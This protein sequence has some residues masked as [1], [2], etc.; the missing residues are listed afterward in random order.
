MQNKTRIIFRA[1]GNS[2]IG[3]GHVVRSLALA[4]MLCHDFECIFAIQ[5]PSP[6]LQEQI[7]QTCDGVIIL[8]VCHYEE[9]RFIYELQA[10]IA[11]D[12][13]VVLDGYHF[14]TA[15]QQNIKRRGCQL[16]CIDDIHTYPFVADYILNQAGGVDAAKYKTASYTKL[17]LGPAF[18]L[19]RPPFLAAAKAE[20]TL[21]AGDVRVFLNLGGADP[22]NHTLQIAKELARIPGIK[23]VEVTVG[24]AY[25]HLPDLQEWVK[26][27]KAYSLHQNLNAEELCQ[28]MQKC[29]V[30]VTS[31]SGVAYEYASVGGRLFI[32]QTAD[33]QA[34]LYTFLTQNNIAQKYEQLEQALQAHLPDSFQQAVKIQRQYLDGRSDERLKQVFQRMALAASITIRCVSENDLMLLF[35]W[36]NDPEVRRYSFNTNPILLE[37]HT[38]WLKTKLE[39]K[40]AKLYVAEA[41]G[42]PLA[43][44]RFEV[45]DSRATISYLL[46]SDFR[47]KGMSHVVLQKCIVKLLQQN[48]KLVLIDGLVQPENVASIKAIM[49]VGFNHASPD[50]KYP[51]AQRFELYT[52]SIK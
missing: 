37:S 19:L 3:L 20:R 45:N 51:Q 33:N 31:A 34:G 49:K 7:K 50:P 17:L 9:D 29:A 16:Y 4:E 25:L 36:A 30:A 48:P 42:V 47:G 32:L 28:L 11:E 13:I 23:N 2:Q 40:Q 43:H 18:A 22:Q 44:V 8:P 46:G 26:K 5:A 10:Y 6:E 24:S 52:D 12:V 21:P 39:D 27:H 14:N 15:Y 35:N 38:R 1:D 41:N